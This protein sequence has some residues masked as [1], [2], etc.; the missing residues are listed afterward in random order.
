MSDVHRGDGA[1][2]DDFA[3]NSLLFKC[4]LDY[5]FREGFTYL[6]LGDAEELWEIES[7]DQIYITY[8]SV[9]KKLQAFHNPDPVKT[10]YLKV[11]GNHDV[12]WKDETGFLDRLFPGIQVYEAF[13]LNKTAL[14]LHGHQADAS[15]YGIGAQMSRFVVKH[16]WTALQRLGLH[17]PTRPA[18]NPGLSNKIDECLHSWTKANDRGINLIIAGHTHRPVYENLSLTERIYLQSNLFTPRIREKRQADRSYFNTG[19]C[20]HPDCITGIEIVT[21]NEK[22]FLNL[23]K[24]GYNVS[25]EEKQWAVGNPEEFNLAVKRTILERSDMPI[26]QSN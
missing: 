18:N 16:L 23:V 17:D 20:V 9:Y 15:C 25:G 10:R 12:C 4:A 26:F 19:S 22:T 6:E 7:F 24:W 13:I 21:E 5:Y 3:H 8:T 1:G 11:W 2:A 14:L